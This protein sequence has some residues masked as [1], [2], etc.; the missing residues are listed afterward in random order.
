MTTTTMTTTTSTT[1]TT[2]AAPVTL[3]TTQK[4]RPPSAPTT[5]PMITSNA[6]PTS[7]PPTTPAATT[8]PAELTT[9]R[10]EEAEAEEQLVVTEG[11]AEGTAAAPAVT[12][13]LDVTVVDGLNGNLDP[14]MPLIIPPHDPDPPPLE[15]VTESRY[16]AP[17][18][19]EGPLSV[20]EPSTPSSSGFPLPTPFPVGQP[21]NSEPSLRLD[22]TQT[23]TTV[24][25]QDSQTTDPEALLWPKKETDTPAESA[26]Q[27]EN[28]TTT[29]SAASVLSGDGEVE[30]TPPYYHQLLDTD[31]ETDYQYDPA[32]A[33]LPVSPAALLLLLLLHLLL[34]ASAASCSS[35]TSL[36]SCRTNNAPPLSSDTSSVK[37]Q[38][39]FPFSLFH[40]LHYLHFSS[41]KTHWILIIFVFVTYSI[42]HSASYPCS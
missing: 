33:F 28:D 29:F 12:V 17:Q 42:S 6:E 41:V 35:S 25:T 11:D 26:I 7:L 15:V 23:P 9:R 37:Q 40:R 8:P 24:P 30:H 27:P 34:R 16:S 21:A 36:P 14:V 38:S 13:K 18:E 1:V 2:S 4:P 31:S 5:P 22:L 10:E 32:D 20:T 19:A 39:F 3:A